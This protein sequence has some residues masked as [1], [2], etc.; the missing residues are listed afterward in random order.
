MAVV[1][2]SVRRA[3]QSR[4]DWNREG[5][6]PDSTYLEAFQNDYIFI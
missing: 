2:E 5:F 4:L 1:G 3:E 6:T